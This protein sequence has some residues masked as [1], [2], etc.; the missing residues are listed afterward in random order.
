MNL[1]ELPWYRIITIS[2]LTG[3]LVNVIVL[4]RNVLLQKEDIPEKVVVTKETQLQPSGACSSSCMEEIQKA[5]RTVSA[6]VGPSTVPAI[7]TP[8]PNSNAVKEYYV[9]LGA[10]SSSSDEWENITGAQAYVDPASFSS[11]KKV[12]FEASMQIPTGNQTAYVRLY[13]VTDSHPVWFSE[14]SLDGGA[15]KL[16]TSDSITLDTGNKLY[17]VQLKT[18]LKY[19]VNLSQSRLKITLN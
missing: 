4:D 15:S 11:I 5:T 8:A 9:P 16:L 13:N 2:L 12:V 17:R 6:S 7:S 1:K 18:Q 14:M 3:L 10:G 19:L